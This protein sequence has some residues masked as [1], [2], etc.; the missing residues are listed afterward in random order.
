MDGMGSDGMGWDQIRSDQI[1]LC[2]C[3]YIYMCVCVSVR[4]YCTYSNLCI[5]FIHLHMFND[6][7]EGILQLL[8]SSNS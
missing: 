7:S 4:V 5:Y 1:R 6:I 3:I 2:A 8:H